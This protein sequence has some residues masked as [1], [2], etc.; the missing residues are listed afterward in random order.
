MVEPIVCS[1]GRLVGRVG[2]YADVCGYVQ[3][4]ADVVNVVWLS[5]ALQQ[6]GLHERKVSQFLKFGK[7]YRKM[8][9]RNF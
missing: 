4:C 1:S 7:F 5:I 9:L 3:M 6:G 2:M 8:A